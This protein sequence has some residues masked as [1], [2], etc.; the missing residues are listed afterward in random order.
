MNIEKLNKKSKSQ[1]MVLADTLFSNYIRTRD[2][3]CL[4]GWI[5]GEPCAGGLQ[6]S[7]VISKGACS[8]LRYD[9]N[10]AKTLCYK[11]HIHG[12][13]GLNHAIYVEWFI[14]YYPKRWK[15]LKEA[16]DTYK[17]TGFKVTKQHY[18]DIIQKY[19]DYRSI[20]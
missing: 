16:F 10:N 17:K 19:W 8:L 11:H 9:P 2:K 6:A 14:K 20:K 3:H 5:N 15:Y 7:H 18:I 12:W 4:Y 1:L 13:H